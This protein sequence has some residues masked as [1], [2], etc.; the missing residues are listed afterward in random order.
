MSRRKFSLNAQITAI[1]DRDEGTPYSLV[2]GRHSITPT[3][4]ARAVRNLETLLIED[5]ETK[6]VLQTIYSNPNRVRELFKMEERFLE[7]QYDRI[8]KEKANRGRGKFY[9]GTF[10][11]PENVNKLIYL[12][13]C[14]HNPELGRGN[15]EKIVEKLVNLPSNLFDYLRFDI[16]LG[17]LMHSALPK[18]KRDSPL[19]ILKIFDREYQQRTG[20]QSLFDL[21]QK[22][23]LHE[24]QFKVG[25]R[26]WERGDNVEQAVYHT[27]TEFDSRLKLGDRRQVIEAIKKLPSKRE[28]FF[29]EVG[30][31]GILHI[32]KK[33]RR[34]KTSSPFTVL[35][36]FD[37]IRQRIT[38]DTSLFDL[39]QE[40][41]LHEWRAG[42]CAP[43]RYW[44]N[45]KNVR[46]AIY[47]V[48]TE[49]H[50]SLKSESRKEVVRTIEQLPSNLRNYFEKLG[51]GGLMENA[52]KMGKKQSP[53]SVLKEFDREYQQTTKEPSLFDLSQRIHL[54]EW[55]IGGNAPQRYWENRKNV[56][57]AVY[58]TL[59]EEHI[60]LGSNDREKVVMAIRQLP[61]NLSNYFREKGLYGLMQS[62]SQG[63]LNS[64]L[65]ILK[66]FDEEY[67]QRTREVSLF[68]RGQKNYINVPG[69]RLGRNR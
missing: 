64:P 1:L 21:S 6:Q 61:P 17:G 35:Y 15:R 28:S 57:R 18:E 69:K 65:K 54:H 31:G 52:F 32:S 49:E 63:N 19:E 7:E 45:R 10:F 44:K 29:R 38:G 56:R 5:K 25:A 51:L 12:A 3:Q 40:I 27:L 67:Q 33:K 34:T 68:D 8:C 59:T 48:L 22:S 50:P 46:R 9:E 47:H 26:Y 53:L 66:I 23:H 30:L 60:F 39:E 36:Y 41:H 55:E 43:Q 62:K 37:K 11:N 2:L 42:G 16:A 13:L 24:W 58:H 20:D 4:F 14:S